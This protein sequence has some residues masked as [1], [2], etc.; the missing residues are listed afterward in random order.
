[1]S[2]APSDEKQLAH[3]PRRLV[4]EH[5]SSDTE[6]PVLERIRALDPAASTGQV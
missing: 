1:M 4:I 2:K 6:P 3:G 5:T